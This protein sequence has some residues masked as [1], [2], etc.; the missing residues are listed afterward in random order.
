MALT[1]FDDILS[2][3]REI[4]S[5]LQGVTGGVVPGRSLRSGERYPLINVIDTNEE[6]VV[7]AELP[8]VKKEDVH[9][10]V[11]NGL[12]TISGERKLAATPE[13][14]QWLRHEIRTGNFSR[15]VGLP[16]QVDTGKISAELS[17]GILRVALPKAEEAKPREV[18]IK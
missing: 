14:S 13:Q 12:L 3:E 17:N 11:D 5:L 9:L 18:K 15:V 16:R 1:V 8:G 2:L 4:G 6:F 10:T 7:V